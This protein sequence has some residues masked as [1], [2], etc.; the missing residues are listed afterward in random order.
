MNLLP[1]P[2]ALERVLHAVSPLPRETVPLGEAG[3]RVLGESLASRV[4]LP[5]FDNS[6]MDGYALRSA[7]AQPLP[8]TLRIVGESRAGFPA[9]VA[10]GAQECVRISTGA[11]MPLGANAVVM[12]EDVTVENGSI[13][14]R[15]SVGAWEN[16]RFR[17]E[18]LRTGHSIA[19]AGQRLTAARLGLLAASG[20]DQVS[21]HR[22][23]KVALIS[24]GSE[25]QPLGATLG[26]GQIYESNSLSIGELVRQCGAEVV[27]HRVVPDDPSATETALRE[28]CSEADAVLSIGGAS[29]G[30]WDLVRPSVEKLGGQLDF[31][32]IAIRPGKPF[33]LGTCLGR[34]FFGVPGNP[35]SAFVTT[36]ILVLPA[37]R[38]MAGLADTAPP[39]VSGILAEPFSNREDR[40]HFM[41][42]NFDA[43]GKIRSAGVQ[44][45]HIQ[46]PLA[47]A[48]GLLP[49]PP[50]TEL[51]SGTVVHVLRW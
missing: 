2:E 32:R 9:A 30:E 14:V 18:D 46:V 50:K 28:A 44:A 40:T 43:T 35:V 45:S 20:V 48:E 6:A 24:T 34:T 21:V 15:E 16:V 22:I 10:V 13:I 29:V 47:V 23:P 42:V 7:D 41:R 17:G 12:Q 8:S 37:L 49:V 31:W 39:T 51:A 36:V 4:D 3:G 11:M 27:S 5:P 25:L 33:F 19:T 38:A 26:P 1:Y